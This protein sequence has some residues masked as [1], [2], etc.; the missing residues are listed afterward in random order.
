MSHTF[1]SL[2]NTWNNRPPTEKEEV[3][4]FRHPRAQVVDGKTRCPSCGAASKDPSILDALPCTDKDAG[5]FSTVQMLDA[6]SIADSASHIAPDYPQLGHIWY[7][8]PSR[9]IWMLTAFNFEQEIKKAEWI[10][11]LSR[12]TREHHGGVGGGR[13]PDTTSLS[14]VEVVGQETITRLPFDQ[15]PLETF[16][17]Y[18]LAMMLVDLAKDAIIPIRPLE[19]SLESDPVSL[20]TRFTASTQTRGILLPSKLKA[21]SA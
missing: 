20:G 10:N 14:H 16:R 2:K 15:D 8:I 3:T 17:E 11:L 4:R 1:Q 13:H 21:F 9:S 12:E 19:V 6:K 18:T 5:V 7:E